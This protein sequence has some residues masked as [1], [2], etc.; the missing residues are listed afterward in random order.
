MPVIG[1][2]HDKF[3]RAKANTPPPPGT[4]QVKGYPAWQS[5][6]VAMS[7]FS[8]PLDRAIWL[9]KAAW[10]LLGSAWARACWMYW[11]AKAVWRWR[12]WAHQIPGTTWTATLD[13]LDLE[14]LAVLE[15]VLSVLQGPQWTA[16][17]SKVR[18]CAQTMGFN[19]PDAWVEYSR[20]LKSNFGQAQ[21]VMRHVKVVHE[22]KM[23]Y[24]EMSNP[25]AHLL[26]ELGYQGFAAQGRRGLKT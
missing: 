22:L 4:N 19:Q 18:G 7:V 6:I 15:R 17:R 21:N 9:M 14:Q 16:A 1:E 23:A 13:G 5:T 12:S 24:P 10:Y 20:L 25:D 8:P 2:F 11:I 26:A 3:W